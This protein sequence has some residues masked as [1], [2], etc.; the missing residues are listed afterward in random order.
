MARSITVA[1]ELDDRGFKRG[2]SSADQQVGKLT[3]GFGGLKTAIG[4]A[5][6][7]AGGFAVKGVLDATLKMENFRTTLTAY[8]G[9]QQAANSELARLSELANQLPQDLDNITEGFLVLQRNGIDTTSDAL[10]AF[11]K[12][13]AGNSK[14]FTQLAEAVADALTGEFERLK[15][16]GIKVSKE[17]DQFAIRFADGSTKIV[18]SAQEVVEAVRQ[19]GEEGGKF[20]DVVAGPLNQALS[21]LNGIIFEASTAFGEGFAPAIAEGATQIKALI[22]ANKEAIASFGE[23]IGDGLM[24]F[25]NNMDT[26]VAGIKAFVA[27]WAVIKFAELVQG[28]VAVRTA[29]I[30]MNAALLANPI[31]LV[32]G[33]IAAATA[34]IV[35]YW[36]EIAAAAVQ[37]WN[38]TQEAWFK[39]KELFYTYVAMPI[40]EVIDWFIMLGNK[41]EAIA[42]A[43]GAA[44]KA[45][46]SLEDP[47]AAFVAALSDM[48]SES[49]AFADRVSAKIAEI[50]Q[51]QE[52]FRVEIENTT[53]ATEELTAAEKEAERAINALSEGTADATETAT[54][55]AT[56]CE[57]LETALGNTTEA[58]EEN[59]DATDENTA[60]TADNTAEQ[61][62]N[63]R[64]RQKAIRTL[65]RQKERINDV[66]GA[67]EDSAR[68]QVDRLENEREL[69]DYFGEERVVQGELNTLRNEHE[70]TEER[71]NR[72]KEQGLITQ[73]QYNEAMAEA[74]TEYETAKV[75]VEE[76]AR[77]N[78]EY[79]RSFEYGFKEAFNNFKE[80]SMNAATLA[81]DLF[82][83]A[84]MDWRNAWVEAA[85]TGKLSFDDLLKNM[86]NRIVAFLAD[87]AFI[88]LTEVIADAFGINVSG[89][90]AGSGGG[91]S[92]SSGGGSG[93]GKNIIDRGIDF[94]KGLFG[95]E[96]GGYVAGNRS[97]I[98]G[99]RG[100]EIFTPSGSGTII[101]NFAGMGGGSGTSVTYNINALDSRSF[102]ELLSSQPQL[103]YNITKSQA[104]ATGDD[105]RMR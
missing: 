13:A 71:L 49:T 74:N 96:Q 38:Y 24:W 14:D 66:T 54:E 95:F 82:E 23:L 53:E 4:A 52:D 77:A 94:V 7:V 25:L 79:S 42:V 70:R 2:L 8:L 56:S 88:K 97:V 45:A 65:E 1:L 6:A 75:K 27:A 18:D 57:K 39:F 55:F 46:L 48:E 103:I 58:T 33:A 72:L 37:A 11:S 16:F 20:A 31:G 81:S 102:V 104:R 59:T 3:S 87:A 99:E 93:S 73:D 78:Y 41:A 34:V 63:E 51:E 9:S 40:A 21:N 15:E 68:A 62:K 26:V 86:R 60:S 64:E 105:V 83:G 98:V 101:P 85:N 69:L 76:L 92:S 30:A 50:K 89:R 17:Q 10:V 47:K 91:S 32:V 36:D 80:D 29:I 61:E 67:F 90:T 28:L 43:V 19:Q 12:V 5:S 100:P 35:V 44:F 22:E 84:A